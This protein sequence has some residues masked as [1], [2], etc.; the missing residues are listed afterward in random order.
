VLQGLPGDL[1]EEPLLRVH[2]ARLAR[3]DPEEAL[4]EAVDLLQPGAEPAGVVVEAALGRGGDG[5]DALA[6]HP[7]VA[8]GAVGAAGEAAADADDGDGLGGGRGR[9]GGRRCGRRLRFGRR[10]AL[11]QVGGEAFHGGVVE[12]DGAGQRARLVLEHGAQLHGRDRVHAEFGEA[13]AAAY[14]PGLVAQHPAHGAGHQVLGGTLVGDGARRFPYGCRCRCRCRC[15]FRFRGRLP[16]RCEGGLGG[17]RAA[18]PHL[19]RLADQP[20]LGVEEPQ[21][22]AESAELAHV[23][24]LVRLP[25]L[26]ADARP[27]PVPGVLPG[28]ARHLH[29]PPVVRRHLAPAHGRPGRVQRAQRAQHARE[30]RGVAA[31]RGHD[32]HV[33]GLGDR[34][35]QHR[36]RADL[37]ERVAVGRQQLR[38]GV[39]EADRLAHV[40]PPVGGGERLALA[41]GGAGHRHARLLGRQPVE[42]AG[43]PAGVGRHRRA[44]EGVVPVQRAAAHAARRQFLAQRVEGGGLA[45]DHGGAGAVDGGHPQPALVGPDRGQC[46]RLRQVERGHASRAGRLREQPAAEDDDA[47]RVGQLQRARDVRGGHLPHAVP[48]HGGR[49]HPPGTPQRGERDLHGEDHRL[50]GLGAVQG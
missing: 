29:R 6:Q 11:A 49:F 24:R 2:D 38:H 39:G 1:E 23:A 37:D 8:L 31:Q 44:V 46:L 17:G 15:P 14:R 45:G 19:V 35:G 34:H 20:A 42:Q 7:P 50:G 21:L 48:D 40:T 28:I 43:E 10:H 41:G 27:Q 9:G 5:V 4:V 36:V 18:Q 12:G 13:L 33:G 3:R 30:T 16:G 26:A 25:R 47:H 32:Q 22:A